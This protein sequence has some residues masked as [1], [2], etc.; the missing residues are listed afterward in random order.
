[1]MD[2]V[3]ILGDGSTWDDNE[4]RFSLRSIAARLQNF[5]NVYVIGSRPK[6]LTNVVHVRESDPY[7]CKEANIARKVLRAC[8]LQ[9]LSE[10][11][12]FMNDDHF[13]LRDCDV[14]VP[15]WRGADLKDFDAPKNNYQRAIKNTFHELTRRGLNR[16]NFDVHVPCVLNKKLFPNIVNSFDWSTK[17][18]FVLKSIYCNTMR[19]EG[20]KLQDIKLNDRMTLTD[21]VQAIKT[22]QWF[23]IGPGL[24]NRA[25]KQFFA[26]F[27]SEK[28]PYEL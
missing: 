12:L 4:L 6:W 18:G 20:V 8:Q 2:V 3:Y 13:L 27:Y 16:Y 15:F 19:V 10:N 7:T 26:E 21:I 5:R 28:S 17:N 23:S 14:N 24:L 25:V 22:R 11:F 9:D 1:M